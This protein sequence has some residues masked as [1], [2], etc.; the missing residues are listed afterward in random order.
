MKS[1]FLILSIS[2]LG[3]AS[4]EKCHD[5]HYEDGTNQIEIGELCGD[6]LEA[7]EANGY[8]LGDTVVTVHC[9]EH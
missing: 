9:E 5:C 4:C 2:I 1:T 7:A 6:E 8:T 3:F